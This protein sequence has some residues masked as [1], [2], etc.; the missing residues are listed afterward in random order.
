MSPK[1]PFPTGLFFDWII[2]GPLRIVSGVDHSF[3]AFSE[4]GWCEGVLSCVPSKVGWKL[5]ASCVLREQR[6][7]HTRDVPSSKRVGG[8]GLGPKLPKLRCSCRCI[9]PRVAKAPASVAVG[10][11]LPSIP[12][13]AAVCHRR[14]NTAGGRD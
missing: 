6:V 7:L 3:C 1:G 12:R 4:G 13:A 8:V 9:R 10:R 11:K 14:I 2:L 5:G